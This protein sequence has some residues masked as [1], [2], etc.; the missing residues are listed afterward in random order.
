MLLESQWV[1]AHSFF[2][3]LLLESYNS[4]HRF[5]KIGI[6]ETYLDSSFSD[7]NPRLNIPGYNKVR[8]VFVLGLVKCLCLLRRFSRCWFGSMPLFKGVPFVQNEKDYVVRYADH[9]VKN[10]M[11]LMIFT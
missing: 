7:D 1:T 10:R 9:P 2:K 3:I 4:Q 8:A 5:D 11:S 6:S